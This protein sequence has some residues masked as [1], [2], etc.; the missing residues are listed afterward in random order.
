M[1]SKIIGAIVVLV[2]AAMI[3]FG[4]T[5]LESY[6]QKRRDDSLA[7]GVWRLEGAVLELQDAKAA[8]GEATPVTSSEWEKL[9]RERQKLGCSAR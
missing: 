2:A 3:A 9:E 4:P 7:C 8:L 5:A 6:Q 1:K